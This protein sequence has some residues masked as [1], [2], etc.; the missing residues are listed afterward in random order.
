[1]L[2]YFL[3]YI[4]TTGNQG[5]AWKLASVSAPATSQSWQVVFEAIRGNGLMGDIAIDDFSIS[6]TGCGGGA[7]PGTFFSP[8]HVT[9]A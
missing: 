9:L 8:Y 3:I 1:M 5:S 4:L 6:T 7:Y 2:F